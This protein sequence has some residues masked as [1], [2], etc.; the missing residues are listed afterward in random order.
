MSSITKQVLGLRTKSTKELRQIYESVFNEPA[1][2]YASSVHLIPKIAYRLQELAI[3]GLS[4]ATK[5]KL[6]KIAS[7]GDPNKLQNKKSLLPGVKI[8]KK[9]KDVIHEVEV[10]KEGYEYMGQSFNSLSAIATKITGTKWNGPKF[11]GLR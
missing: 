4:K 6:M 5:D 8:R 9:Y 11:F 7:G 1:P 3:G 2:F 10:K